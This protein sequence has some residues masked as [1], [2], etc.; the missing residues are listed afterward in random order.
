MSKL[1]YEEIENVNISLLNKLNY[2]QKPF[3]KENTKSNWLPWIIAI[4]DKVFQKTEVIAS[5]LIEWYYHNPKRKTWKGALQEK[6]IK[7]QHS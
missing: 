7:D 1:A 3:P 5:Q 2:N 6:E 4:L